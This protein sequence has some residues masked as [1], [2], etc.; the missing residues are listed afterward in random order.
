MIESKREKD[1]YIVKE[2]AS[3]ILG[4]D[5]QKNLVK[6]IFNILKPQMQ[7]KVLKIIKNGFEQLY[8]WLSPNP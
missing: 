6:D 4:I 1:L 3:F 5:E 7:K 8:D 2:M